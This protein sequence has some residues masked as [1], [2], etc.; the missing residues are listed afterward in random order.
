MSWKVGI[1]IHMAATVNRGELTAS[2]LSPQVLGGGTWGARISPVHS[3]QLTVASISILICTEIVHYLSWN[4]SIV[5]HMA[6]TVNRGEINGDTFAPPVLGRGT[7]GARVSPV[8]SLQLTVASISIL[9]CTEIVHYLSW[10]VSIVIH[11]AATVNR[12][13]INGDTF[14]PPVLGRGTWGARVSPVH[15]LQLTVASISILIY[16]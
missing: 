12:G 1:V 3:L 15:S 6:A 2:T 7:W 16:T 14:A 4:V 8:H 10:N 13:E 9:I 5:I 11:M